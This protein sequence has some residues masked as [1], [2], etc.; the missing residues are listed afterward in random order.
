MYVCMYVCMFVTAV[1]VLFLLKLI[2]H[3]LK[4]WNIGQCNSGVFVRS[5]IVV[6]DYTMLYKYAKRSRNFLARVYFYFSLV[7]YVLVA[8]IIT[9]SFYSRLL[10]MR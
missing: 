10:D 7:F 9:Q 3:F 8:F 2:W 4:N 1:C 6:C 5:A